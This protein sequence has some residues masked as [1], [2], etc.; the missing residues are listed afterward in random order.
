MSHMT[1]AGA[2]SLS[3]HDNRTIVIEVTGICHNLARKSNL[4]IKVPYSR[5]SQALQRLMRIRG[6]VTG[7]K[8]VSFSLTETQSAQIPALP[9]EKVSREVESS[10]N[11]QAQ[12][13]DIVKAKPLQRSKNRSVLKKTNRTKK[14]RRRRTIKGRTRV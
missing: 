12:N 2:M 1:T 11:A 3:S 6:K 9:M 14:A 13:T 5:L 10:N 4:T 8:L 7:V